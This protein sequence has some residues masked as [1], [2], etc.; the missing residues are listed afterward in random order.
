MLY[1]FVSAKIEKTIAADVFRH[2]QVCATAHTALRS[3]EGRGFDAK[4]ERADRLNSLAK[5]LV[6]NLVKYLDMF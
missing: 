6:K 3:R 5:Y 2:L 1:A 4:K